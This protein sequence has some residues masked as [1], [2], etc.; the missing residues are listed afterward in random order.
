M[1]GTV[2]NGRG[3]R[4]HST[5]CAASRVRSRKILRQH[6][7]RAVACTARGGG[8]MNF[9]KGLAKEIKKS[10]FDIC[11]N[12][13][14]ISRGKKNVLLLSGTR[15]FCWDRGFVGTEGRDL[16]SCA[17][18]RVVEY[19]PLERDRASVPKFDSESRGGLRG[20]ASEGELFDRAPHGPTVFVLRVSP[21]QS[22][23]VR[24]FLLF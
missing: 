13:E 24:P 16:I 1:T 15:C 5:C 18:R 21:K 10:F 2:W 22:S 17:L 7:R 20:S 14:I 8:V 3:V 4:Q 9:E 6:S 19:G 23:G 11:R 12:Y